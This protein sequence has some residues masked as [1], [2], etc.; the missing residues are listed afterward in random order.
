MA[1]LVPDS[2]DEAE[3]ALRTLVDG[4]TWSV[5]R[6]RAALACGGTAGGPADGQSSGSSAGTVYGLPPK[7]T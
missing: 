6:N 2:P 3:I 4:R 5:T 7:L 1:A